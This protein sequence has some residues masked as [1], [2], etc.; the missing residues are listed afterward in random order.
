RTTA[1]F[2]PSRGSA[3]IFGALAAAAFFGAVFFWAVLVG[4][5]SSQTG[6]A[7]AFEPKGGIALTVQRGCDSD[8]ICRLWLLPEGEEA[9]GDVGERRVAA[10]HPIEQLPGARQVTG[11]FAQVGQRV[12]NPQ[13]MLGRS[14]YVAAPTFEHRHRITQAPAVGERARHH[15]APLRHQRRRRR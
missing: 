2:R 10:P 8:A 4:M 5:T 6:R 13:M 1:T 15:D 14:L 7:R 3:S 12:P 11:A 9:F